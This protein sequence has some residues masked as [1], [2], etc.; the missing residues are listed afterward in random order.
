[1]MASMRT[2]STIDESFARLHVAGW[3]VGDVQIRTA[4][5]DVYW[6]VDGVNGESR[7]GI[8]NEHL[9]EDVGDEK[10]E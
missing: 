9:D 5:G 4:A 10:V 8:P 1:M 6:L 3:S 2:V 7:I